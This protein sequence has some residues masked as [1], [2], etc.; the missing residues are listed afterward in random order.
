MQQQLTSNCKNCDRPDHVE[1]MVACDKCNTWWHFGCADVTE[2]VADRSWKCNNCSTFCDSIKS[3]RST[4][5]ARLR[6]KQL[7]ERKALDD[8]Q[9]QR[10]REYLA[11]K[12]QLEAEVDAENEDNSKSYSSRHNSE[13]VRCW[14]EHQNSGSEE[15]TFPDMNMSTPITSN[16]CNP[17]HSAGT[18]PDLQAVP[19]NSALV[20]QSLY[21]TAP[22]SAPQRPRHATE[23]VGRPSGLT[24]YD[25]TRYTM[26][27]P[28]GNKP[29]HVYLPDTPY[30]LQKHM[31]LPTELSLH[32]T[33]PGPAL[34]QQTVVGPNLPI[35][36]SVAQPEV[37]WSSYYANGLPRI[38]PLVT[39]YVLPPLTRSEV[40]GP[41]GGIYGTGFKPML[42]KNATS[43]PSFAVQP[44]LNTIVSGNAPVVTSN[45]LQQFTGSNGLGIAAEMYGILPD[46][47]RTK[48]TISAP[49][50]PAQLPQFA[51]PPNPIFAG[52]NQP[53]YGNLQ[54][55]SSTWP[56]DGV[57]TPQQL[58]ARHVVSKELPKFSGDP[59]EWPMFLSAFESTT[60]MCGIQPDENLAR[61][62]KS[63][64]GSA[65]DKVQSILTLPSAVPEIISTL[66][67][68]CGRPEQLVYCLLTRIR[69]AP[70]PNV[71]KLETLVTFEREVRNLVT[72]IEAANLHSHLSNPMLLTE[73][74]G[75]LPPSLRLDWGL[76]SQRV[77]QVTLKA[78]SDYVSCIK[79]AACHVNLPVDCGGEGGGVKR[80]A[81]KDKDGF[82][83]AHLADDESKYEQEE[84]SPRNATYQREKMKPC[85]AC[86]RTN[87]RIRECETFVKLSL[88]ERLNLVEQIGLCKSCLSRHGKWP[89]RNKQ[90]CGINDCKE[91]HHKLLHAFS[92]TSI[93]KFSQVE[94]SAIVSAHS[95]HKMTSLFKIIPV[96]LGNKG[97][98]V[99][100]FAFLDDGSDLTLLENKLANE[101]GL[102]GVESSLCLQWTGSVTRRESF[103]KKVKLTI[104]GMG[105]KAV[106]TLQ[107]VRTVD[108]LGLPKQTLDFHK[109]SQRYSFLQGLPIESYEE[110]MP[111]IL[112]GVDN[113]RLKLPLNKRDRGDSEPVAI[114]TRLGWTIFGGRRESG[115]PE[116]LM[117]HVCNCS[118]DREL[119]DL[120]KDY[121]AMEDI[122]V[123]GV[124]VPETAEDCRARNILE[125]TTRRTASGKFET[126]L[127][128]RTD[129][130]KFPN[131]LPMA[132][133]RLKCLERRL[134]LDP[135]LQRSVATLIDEY[136]E[137][138]YAHK[139]TAKELQ[140]SDPRKIWYLPL[141]VVRNPRKPN[142]IRIIWDAAATV[143]EV[144]LNSMLLKGPDLLKP[145]LSV[146]CRFRQRQFAIAADIRQM[147]HQLLVREEDR[148]S[149]RFLWRTDPASPPEIFVMDVVTFGASCSPCS[150]QYVKNVN[151]LEYADRYPEAALAI[152][153]NTYVDDYLD[154]RDTIEQAVNLAVEVRVI[155]GKAG[156]EIRN[157]QSNS[158]QIL[159][160]VGEVKPQT[161]KTFTAEKLTSVERIL[162]MIW[163]PNE[164]V[165]VFTAQF[166]P[167]LQPLLSGE[168]TPTKRQVLQVVMSLFDPLGI[169]S[170]FTIHG[171]IL[172]QDVWRSGIDWDEPITEADFVNW[173]RWVKKSPELDRVRIPRCYFPG[174]KKYSYDSL[175]LHMF[176]D[177]SEKAYCAVAYFRIIEDGAPRCA[178]VTSKTRVTPLR[179]QSIPKNELNAAVLGVRLIKT[180]VDNHTLPIKKRFIWT[181]ST[182]VLSWLKADP[183]KYRPYVA[184]RVSEILAESNIE[185]WRWVPT[186][187]NIADGAT[188][189]GAGPSFDPESSW[190]HGP[191]LLYLPETQWPPRK[192][193]L[194]IP[195]DELR[196]VHVHQETP[197]QPFIEFSNFSR[198][199]D[200]LK[201]LAY[202]HHFLNNCR[203]KGTT[204]KK[205]HEMVLSQRDYM[206][207]EKS[208]WRMVQVEAYAAEIAILQT[209][210]SLPEVQ[211][212]RLTNASQLS[213]LSPF[214]DEDGIVRLESRIDPE[215]AYYCFDF[216]NP[217]ILP[218]KSYVTELLVLRLHQRYGHANKSTVMNELQQKYYIPKMRSLIN[219]VM[220]NCSW[221]RVYRAK[222]S[223]P[224]MAPLPQ[225]RVQPYVRPFEFTGI[226]YFGPLIVKRGR[227]N[228]KRWVALFTCL[229][230]RAVHLE[231]VHSLSAES[232]KMAI[233]RFVSRRGTPRHIFSDNG[234]NFRGVAK[235]LAQEIKNIN[236]SI[237]ASFVSA[238]TAWSFNPPSAPHMGGVWERKVRSVKEAFK[239]LSHRDKLEDES[240]ATLLI[241]AEMIVNSHPLTS[242]P[243]DSPEQK[244]LT[245]NDFLIINTGGTNSPER[246]PVHEGVSLRTSWKLMQHLLN[247][248]WKRWIQS[249]LPTIARRTKW[250]SEVRP[251]REDDLVV[252]VDETVRNGWLRGRVI[253]VYTN[254][255]GQVR[256]V[257]VQTNSGVLQRP[258]I[259]VALLDVVDVSKTDP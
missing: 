85:H 243:L 88:M 207:A 244:V 181:D 115:E 242:V 1:N 6:L 194:E 156:F 37:T 196:I 86:Q 161:E 39:P 4:I 57:I 228:E 45:T 258:A 95:T 97:K 192:I 42:N 21:T 46:A 133:R 206:A 105:N 72:Y 67:D 219:R 83:N 89:C 247:Q 135:E 112:I 153:E 73:L 38:A 111:G 202:L 49:S 43:E 54:Q 104:A 34:F 93:D 170:T 2:S 229:T 99:E 158:Q 58:A 208:L 123:Y 239:V 224:K 199:E 91:P 259:K 82:I 22:I 212:K 25:Q 41:A 52:L 62:Q 117:I 29:K 255:D 90:P 222:P 134:R 30:G 61:L 94:P 214:L 187:D 9:V 155:H 76:H 197:T 5:S 166:R 193:K 149:Q 218:N 79:T 130:F 65:R 143:G 140:G 131:S 11:Q 238:E 78:F 257:D 109:L 129:N 213:R 180:I 146:L 203:L 74:V 10:D 174:Y 101:L 195:T 190:F 75:K 221:C 163:V 106:H 230:I 248:F 132:E 63:L 217:I 225:A 124:T 227:T 119:N 136:Q 44:R 139:I 18:V 55:S 32:D 252:I 7:E 87:H 12:H 233:R 232:C 71:N 171:K 159:A 164:D 141:G 70:A 26:N 198:L 253:K 113:A 60:A 110:A 116:R 47:Q 138:G 35:N 103:S 28:S 81:R 118:P 223:E 126:G 235:E 246:T 128:W 200:I 175:E 184:F 151:A 107:D 256:K 173:Q 168:I 15:V 254:S 209:N 24:Q 179:P 211:R 182:T 23:Q 122:G 245:P 157:W 3:V 205:T 250:Y 27:L 114:K 8:L 84:P 56:S 36:Y 33:A 68:E 31:P 77:P 236:H 142:K 16:T 121:F 189:W 127:L 148:Q 237:A 92:S 169:V 231:V 172:I 120:M 249:Y 48:V 160:R 215:A 80:G 17:G 147:F 50:I 69:G 96:V 251:L 186:K 53:T 108:N 59:L 162:G 51:E 226:D 40:P 66:R 20:A 137:R 178:L 152:I 241:E 100:T 216:R 14:V 102:E 191:E 188:K 204:P 19:G 13:H 98:S 240:F 165:F 154:S 185:D 125:R 144:S 220:K 167:D 64:V 176:V 183:R 150:A 145:L 210:S 201:K 234:T 177:A